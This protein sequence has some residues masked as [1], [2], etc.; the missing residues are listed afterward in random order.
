[1][2][3]LQADKGNKFVVSSHESYERQGDKHTMMDR[4]VEEGEK[5]QVQSRMNLCE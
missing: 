2:S 5:E 3:I 4:K 1:M